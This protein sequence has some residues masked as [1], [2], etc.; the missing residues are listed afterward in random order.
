MY[1]YT[2]QNW[3][4]AIVAGFSQVPVDKMEGIEDQFQDAI[5]EIIEGG[6]EKFDLERIGTIIDNMMLARQGKIENGPQE[7]IPNAIVADILYSTKASDLNTFLK[8]GD[9]ETAQNMK[10]KPVQFWL[11][12]LKETLCR[13]NGKPRIKILAYPNADY[14]K[15]L[16]ANETQRIDEQRKEM[17]EEGMKEAGLVVKQALENTNLPP[18]SVLLKIPFAMSP[19]S[20]AFWSTAS[21]TSCV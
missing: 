7:V 1:L 19:S 17:G 5:Q 10:D 20:F 3:E 8:Q 13:C 21:L 6:S 2:I 4:P 14:N 18:D 15:E 12:L 11:N 16:V 9:L